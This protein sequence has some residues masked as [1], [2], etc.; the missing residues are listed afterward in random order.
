VTSGALMAGILGGLGGSPAVSPAA[1]A[2]LRG[3]AALQRGQLGD[4]V[5]ELRIA[6]DL[7]LPPAWAWLAL[8]L[9]EQGALADA[10]EAGGRALALD[11]RTPEVTGAVSLALTRGGRAGEGV[12]LAVRTLRQDPSNQHAAIALL[13]QGPQV[14]NRGLEAIALARSKGGPPES[15]FLVELNAA[16]LLE[17]AGRPGDAAD[18]FL[19]ALRFAP[20]Q[21]RGSGLAAMTLESAARNRY[22]AGQLRE[23]RVLAE[24]AVTGEPG[25]ARAHA[26]LGAIAIAEGGHVQARE[27]FRAALGR[28]PDRLA[29]SELAAALE[30]E[31]QRTGSAVFS[32]Y[33]AWVL[34]EAGDHGPARERFLALRDGSGN[35]PVTLRDEVSQ[36]VGDGG[37]R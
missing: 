23:A 18:A 16:N 35:L 5:R 33:A 15:E 24:R 14:L 4:A 11:A 1:Q 7:G 8:A 6:A 36:A 37:A 10:V 9:V 25:V 2:W 13:A 19:R 26:T 27:H 12:E 34:R 17:A 22:R 30:L 32:F 21:L 29:G 31:A 3:Q 28:H 20:A